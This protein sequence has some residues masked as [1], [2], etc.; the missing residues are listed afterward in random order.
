MQVFDYLIYFI[1]FNNL[2]NLFAV[3]HVTYSGPHEGKTVVF[4]FFLFF[5]HRADI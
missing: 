2:F 3:N 5:M 1:L 4:T